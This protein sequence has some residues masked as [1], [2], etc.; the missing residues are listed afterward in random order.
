MYN[1]QSGTQWR[2]LTHEEEE[3][4]GVYV[5][6]RMD[7]E[8]RGKRQVDNEE[9]DFLGRTKQTMMKKTHC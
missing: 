2:S 7:W 8:V 4:R 6:R 5:W 3:E 9:A 1:G